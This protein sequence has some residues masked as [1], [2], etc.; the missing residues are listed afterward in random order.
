[1][2][3][4]MLV[5]LL[6]MSAAAGAQTT[7]APTPADEAK[8]E[9]EEAKV[10]AKLDEARARLDKAAQ[11]VAELSMQLGR[12]AM[13]GE[14]GIR[15]MRIDGDHRAVL[16]VQIDNASDKAGA[17]VMHVSPGGAAEEAGIRDGDVI[18]SIDGIRDAFVA[19]AAGKLNCTVECNPLIG[20]QLFDAVEAIMAKKEL[21]KRIEVKEGVYEQS[22]AAA[23]LPNRKY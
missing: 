8:R 19:M 5:C 3:H 11:E 13:G 22:Q 14:H 2:K 21:P 16:G 1:M 15:T 12:D 4:L 20:P 17:R 23:E 7:A 9:A 6:A 10:R 18:V